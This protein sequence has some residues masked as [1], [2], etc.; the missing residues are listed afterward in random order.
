MTIMSSTIVKPC[1]W[2]K[3]VAARL[4]DVIGDGTGEGDDSGMAGLRIQQHYTGCSRL[5]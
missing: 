2:A 1:F 5:L 3:G 4:S